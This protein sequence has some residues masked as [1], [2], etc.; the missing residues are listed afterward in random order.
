MLC[1]WSSRRQRIILGPVSKCSVPGL[2][3]E[4]LYKSRLAGA[5]IYLVYQSFSSRA[6]CCSCQCNT[7]SVMIN[8]IISEQTLCFLACL[9]QIYSTAMLKSQKNQSVVK[10][11][12]NEGQAAPSE[13]SHHCTDLALRLPIAF[14]KEYGIYCHIHEMKCKT[15]HF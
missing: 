10:L 3:R 15:K 12:A 5:S 4:N 14:R 7:G 6:L 9:P 11:V 13:F 1:H 8:G 2:S